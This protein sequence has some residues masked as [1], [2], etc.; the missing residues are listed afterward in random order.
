MSETTLVE[1]PHCGDITEHEIVLTEFT[2]GK[3][4]RPFRPN[5]TDLPPYV[6]A[7]QWKDEAWLALSKDAAR[8]KSAAELQQLVAGPRR[9]PFG[10]EAYQVMRGGET[11]IYPSKEAAL[12]SPDLCEVPASVA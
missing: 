8:P 9:H 2:C 12:T 4:D 6:V 11:L 7:G 3:C 10:A 5:A 1:C